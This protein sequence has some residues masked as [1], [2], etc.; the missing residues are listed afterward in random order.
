MNSGVTSSDIARS[1]VAGIDREWR[2]RVAIEGS[3]WWYKTGELE[4]GEVY[5][6]DIKD[7]VPGDE[8]FDILD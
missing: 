1:G 5:I 6:R 8:W 2:R 4:I 3:E 7:R